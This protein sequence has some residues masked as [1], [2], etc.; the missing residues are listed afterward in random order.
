MRMRKELVG[1]IF[2]ILCLAVLFSLS[3]IVSFIVCRCFGWNWTWLTAVG[4]T[5][6][7]VCLLGTIYVAMGVTDEEGDEE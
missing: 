7:W 1:L 5:V 3:A 2:L 6:L 4:T